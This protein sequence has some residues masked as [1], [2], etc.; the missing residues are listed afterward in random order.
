[1]SII[2]VSSLSR[3][4]MDRLGNNLGRSKRPID[5]SSDSSSRRV[6]AAVNRS[7]A[8]AGER[9]DR[10]EPSGGHHGRR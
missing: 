8:G 10:L 5:R 9:V 4:D 2:P 3:S 7:L 1:M 6:L